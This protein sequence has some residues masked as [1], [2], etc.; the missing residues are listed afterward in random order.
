MRFET[1]VRQYYDIGDIL[2]F[3]QEGKDSVKV[4]LVQ[5]VDTYVFI[6]V[7]YDSNKEMRPI[8]VHD[9]NWGGFYQGELYT[10][11]N[12]QEFLDALPDSLKRLLLPGSDIRIPYVEELFTKTTYVK[13]EDYKKKKRAVFWEPMR[14]RRNRVAYLGCDGESC[15]AYWL[16]NAVIG[17]SNRRFMAV[18]VNGNYFSKD[19]PA[20]I[21]G[22]R[23]VYT[24]SLYP[25][26]V[27][28]SDPRCVNIYK[29]EFNDKDSV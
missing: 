7:S 24:L 18:D 5:K 2:K 22:V 14:S 11:L 28:I 8:N 27:A 25:K 16:A 1:F 23:P 9:V 13:Y 6:A 12:S 19:H 20:S 4:M 29:E 26:E 17:N 3:E 10:Y 21:C 15:E